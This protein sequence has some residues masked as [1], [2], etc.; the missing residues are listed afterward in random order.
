[1]S[2]IVDLIDS[3]LSNVEDTVVIERVRKEVNSMM[4]DRPLFAW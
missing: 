3:V 1:M 4:S 2:K